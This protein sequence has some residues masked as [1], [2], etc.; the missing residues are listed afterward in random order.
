MLT[1]PVASTTPELSLSVR[2]SSRIFVKHDSRSLPLSLS[3]SAVPSSRVSQCKGTK[4]QGR[5]SEGADWK[6]ARVGQS[7]INTAIKPAA[8]PDGTRKTNRS[9]TAQQV[10]DALLLYFADLVHLMVSSPLGSG[11]KWLC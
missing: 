2:R 9:D 1:H 10:A 11:M 8:M 3:L 7:A 6:S 4:T 5:I